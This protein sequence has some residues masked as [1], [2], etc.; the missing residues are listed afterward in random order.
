MSQLESKL[1]C[2]PLFVFGIDPGLLHTL[3][4]EERLRV[5]PTQ[6]IERR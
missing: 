1:D 3:L 4:V 5:I 6:T 2:T